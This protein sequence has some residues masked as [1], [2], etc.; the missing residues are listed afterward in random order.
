MRYF[1]KCIKNYVTFEGRASRA[2]FWYFVLCSLLFTLAAALVDL[3]LFDE[4]TLR[5]GGVFYPI[6]CIFFLLPSIAVTVRRMHDIDRSGKR[7]LWYVLFTAAWVAALL[8]GTLL[9]FA[10]GA[11]GGEPPL[12]AK[13]FMGVIGFCAVVTVV[14]G[15][16]FLVWCAR[17]GTPGDNR[18]GADPLAEA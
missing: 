5:A 11:V 12:W 17:R 9:F 8:V 15:V 1:V 14:W 16:L 6:A 7:V 13:V 3:A 2:E 18:Y 10:A 4:A